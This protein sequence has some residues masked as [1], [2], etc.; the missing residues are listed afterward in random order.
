MLQTSS[1]CAYHRQHCCDKKAHF[2]AV[3]SLQWQSARASFLNADGPPAAQL[4][5]RQHKLT[6]CCLLHVGRQRQ[7]AKRRQ[8]SLWRR[9][10]FL[11][12]Q[13]VERRLWSRSG[14]E[15]KRRGE[16]VSMCKGALCNVQEGADARTPPFPL[17]APVPARSAKASMPRA[18]TRRG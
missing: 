6:L 1:P 15:A 10:A 11:W 9:A 16:G 13:A 18:Q 5:A 7:V 4:M 2:H 8:H 12:E 14:R 3:Y 17:N